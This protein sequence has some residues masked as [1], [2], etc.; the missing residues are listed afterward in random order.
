MSHNLFNLK[1]RQENERLM[2]SKVAEWFAADDER[3]RR[4]FEDFRNALNKFATEN[5]KRIGEDPEFRLK[6]HQMCAQMEIDPLAST[7][8][9]WSKALGTEFSD[10]YFLI[11]RR[12]IYLSIKF[13]PQNGGIMPMTDLLREINAEYK[14]PQSAFSSYPSRVEM[15]DVETAIKKLKALSSGYAIFTNA[16]GVRM[17]RSVP[18]E[19]SSDHTAILNHCRSKKQTYFTVPSIVRSLPEWHKDRADEAVDFLLRNGLVWEDEYHP[20][21]KAYWFR[22]LD[23]WGAAH[24]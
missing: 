5:R 15:G 14:P 4:Q 20:D 3:I 23:D 24:K 7:E 12:V 9:S 10:F 16:A 11:A 2:Q 6:F 13:R 17:L 8:G 19:L 1:R 22:S 18:I 21:G